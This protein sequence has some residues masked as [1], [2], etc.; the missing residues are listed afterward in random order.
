MSLYRVHVNIVSGQK[1]FLFF[2]TLP[3]TYSLE[4]AFHTFRLCVVVAVA[5]DLL[6]EIHIA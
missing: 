1:L 6:L 3:L 2:L 5:L 4:N